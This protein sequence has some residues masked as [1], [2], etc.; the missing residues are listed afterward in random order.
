MK[1]ELLASDSLSAINDMEP[2]QYTAYWL[3]RLKNVSD[4]NNSVAG[5]SDTYK[6]IAN[7][8]CAVSV[9]KI[10]RYPPK[11]RN[12]ISLSYY[13]FI[14]ELSFDDP[15]CLY[16]DGF[17][18][19]ILSMNNGPLVGFVSNL[20]DNALELGDFTQDEKEKIQIA[21]LQNKKP[22]IEDA[23]LNE[24]MKHLSV[25]AKQKQNH[26]IE[27]AKKLIGTRSVLFMQMMLFCDMIIQVRVNQKPL[28]RK[29]L[30]SLG[31]FSHRGYLA[32]ASSYNNDLQNVIN[33]N[34]SKQGF[35]K[36]EVPPISGDELFSTILALYK[37]KTVLVDFWRTTCGPC[38]KIIQE[39][40][41]VKEMLAD[42]EIVYI[43]LTNEALSPL[44]AWG[45][46]I[47]GIPGEHYRLN[48]DQW[49]SLFKDTEIRSYPT[50]L[51]VDKTGK[52]TR[53]ADFSSSVIK[54][55]LLKST[56]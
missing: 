52:V 13:Q 51:L 2:E 54:E 50:Y 40:K 25:C 36:R 32:V 37:G 11:N 44:D 46:I 5:I 34:R 1:I 16:V 43:Y 30:Y 28:D 49:K 41:P 18:E 23:R 20:V 42:K 21:F 15:L 48:S 9:V 39:L 4:A 26:T 56:E 7:L 8:S 19:M 27:N 22:D 14:T 53:L 33:A 47:L 35:V 45:N 17:F 12:K 38:L 31:M 6:K 29:Q 24:F 3:N 55:A 10:L